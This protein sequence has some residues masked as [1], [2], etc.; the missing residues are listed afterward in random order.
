MGEV[1]LG[2]GVD[3]VAV[4]EGTVVDEGALVDVV[5]V[6]TTVDGGNGEAVVGASVGSCVD[7]DGGGGGAVVVLVDG[8]T[9]AV[10]DST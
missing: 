5:A 1:V 6:G 10:D 8:S 2:D 4:D 9:D 3:G 7:V